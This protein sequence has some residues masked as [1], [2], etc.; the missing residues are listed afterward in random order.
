MY[1]VYIHTN[2]EN[3]KCYIGITAQSILNRWKNG[4]GYKS[5]KLFYRAIQ[6]YGWN[7]FEHIIF[8]ENLSKEK[9]YET[10]IALIALYKT[11]DRSHGYNISNGGEKTTLGMKL[12]NEARKNMS[13]SHKGKKQPKELVKKRTLKISGTNHWLYGKHWDETTKEKMR[14]AKLGKKQS[15]NQIENAAKSR[16]KQIECIEIGEIYPSVKEAAKKLG[17]RRNVISEA[18]RGKNGRKST[19]GYHFRYLNDKSNPRTE[20]KLKE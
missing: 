6:K 12:S 18:A 10:E 19:G 15:K 8:A 2:K 7:N 16:W 9:A 1:T 3:N 13:D 20:I 14:N 5:Q 11:N 4:N 17:L